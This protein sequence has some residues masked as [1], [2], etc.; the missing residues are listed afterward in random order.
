MLENF[1]TNVLNIGSIN[2]RC[3]G[4]EPALLPRTHERT[5]QIEPMFNTN[6]QCKTQTRLVSLVEYIT[7]VS[8]NMLG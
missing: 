1:R 3:S 2:S 8:L 4:K 6:G 7:R 5:P